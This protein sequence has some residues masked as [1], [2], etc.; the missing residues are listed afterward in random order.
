MFWKI[1]GIKEVHGNIKKKIWCIEKSDVIF[2]WTS[3]IFPIF[4]KWQKSF[5]RVKSFTRDTRLA[6]EHTCNCL[7]DICWV[8][9]LLY[10]LL[11][12][13]SSKVVLKLP[14]G[15]FCD[16]I[17]LSLQPDSIWA[18]IRQINFTI[19]W[20]RYLTSGICWCRES[21]IECQIVLHKYDLLYDINRHWL[22][23]DKFTIPSHY[24]LLWQ[25]LKATLIF[26]NFKEV[27]KYHKWIH[28]PTLLHNIVTQPPSFVAGLG[29]W[30]QKN[31][32]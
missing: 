2:I 10:L 4:E 15:T 12:G 7:I 9:K 8:V 24:A 18:K 28:C 26:A 25:T 11:P 6:I 20:C 21:H 29:D 30:H 27:W 3:E 22:I 13:L 32:G 17:P 5:R 19:S 23:K 1:V 31:W 16:V 14:N